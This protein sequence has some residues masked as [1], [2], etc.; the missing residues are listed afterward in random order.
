MRRGGWDMR[1]ATEFG[2]GAK[3][4]TGPFLTAASNDPIEVKYIRT[5]IEVR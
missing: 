5:P 4:I 2:S 1:L 3:P